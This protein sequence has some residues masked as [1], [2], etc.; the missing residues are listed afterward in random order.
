[1][2]SRT[3]A[4]MKLV[5]IVLEG[6]QDTFRE[7]CFLVETPFGNVTLV[8]FI[9]WFITQSKYCQQYYDAI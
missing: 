4:L 3:V 6:H 7:R 8:A 2:T 5:G 1:M 9:C